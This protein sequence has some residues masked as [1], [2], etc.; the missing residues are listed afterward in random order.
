MKM[1]L[2]ILI[3]TTVASAQVRTFKWNSEACIFS[4]TYNSKRYTEKQLRNTA[5]LITFGNF[6]IEYF[7]FVFKPEDIGMLDIT[8]LENEYRRKSA[9]LNS[10][11]LVPG[12]FWEDVRKRK[13]REI[14][15]V[16]ARRRAETLAYRDPTVLR[17]YEGAPACNAK[18][19][20]PLIAGGESLYKVWLDVNLE[21]RKKN[22]DPERL[23]RKFE[24]E[25]ASPDRDKFA[26]VEVMAFGW[27]NCSNALVEYDT[28]GQ[29]GSY[30][31]QF[32]KLF[33]R[34]KEVCDE[35]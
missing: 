8:K 9:D 23:R 30:L 17:Q 25:M 33:L 15:Q 22:A 14:D 6:D 1:F 35:A 11:E 20:E 34:V 16:Y 27:G 7:A 13:L 2:P 24:A 10:L 4:G 3:L 19:A 26:F 29:D 18:Y 28:A 31:K 32:K 21:S 12:K 5:R